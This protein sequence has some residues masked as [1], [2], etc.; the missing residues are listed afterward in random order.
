MDKYSYDSEFVKEIFNK[1]LDLYDIDDWRFLAEFNEYHH[2]RWIE[3]SLSLL[4]DNLQHRLAYEKLYKHFLKR[5]GILPSRKKL[6]G[7]L[8]QTRGRPP[9]Q[10]EHERIRKLIYPLKENGMTDEKALEYLISIDIIGEI[11]IRTFRRIKNGK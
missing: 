3:T 6:K 10:L 7:L 5:F 9:K 1:D 11:D 4:K 2:R 8:N